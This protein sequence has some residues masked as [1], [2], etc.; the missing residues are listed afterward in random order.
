MQDRGR[1]GVRRAHV[2]DQP[3]TPESS[4]S[5]GSAEQIGREAALQV[6]LISGW[7]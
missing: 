5:R 4:L 1:E 7:T 6:D 3:K 2:A